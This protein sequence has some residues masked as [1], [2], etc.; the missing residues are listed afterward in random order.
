MKKQ[1]LKITNYKGKTIEVVCLAC[2]REKEEINLGDIV[3]SMYFDAHQD[4]E[5]P[6]PGLI[7]ISSRRHIQSIDEFTKKEQVDFI[8]F[9][10]RIRSALRKKL[11]VKTVYLYQR[12]DTKH[13]FHVCMLPRYDWMNKKFGRKIGSVR[14][15]VNYARKH[16]KTKKKI[17]EVEN[18]TRKLKNHF[19]RLKR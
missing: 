19:T 14:A 5:V 6:I 16:H 8:Q 13:H 18:A 12:E 10:C 15:I 17:T 3:K 1:S 4:Y 2:A 11:G 9:L 7:I